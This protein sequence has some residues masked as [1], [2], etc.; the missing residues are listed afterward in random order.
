MNSTERHE[1]RYL[2]RLEKRMIKR[3]QSYSKYD[4][5]D[6]IFTYVNL[7]KSYRLSI[8]NVRWKP[9]IQK[10]IANAP[11]NV[12]K[13]F[14]ELKNGTF[15]SPGFFEF[16]V[17]ERGKKRHIR[18]V[19]VHERVV[20]RCICDNSLIPILSRTFIYDNGASMK[21]KGISFALNRIQCHLQRFIRK[22]GPNGY[23]LNFDFSKFF[24]NINHDVLRDII[25]KNFNDERVKALVFHFIDMFG[26][27]GLGL[28]SQV[29]Q[30]LSL[31]SAN[32]LDHY[33]KE[34]LRCPFYGRYMDDGYIIS[35]SKEFLSKCLDALKMIC[36]KL[37]IT[38]N[39]KKTR[40]TPLRR[41]FTF[42]KTRFFVTETGKIIK[43]ICHSSVTRM[44]RKMKKFKKKLECGKMTMA[45][46]YQSFQS[47][48]SHIRNAM[49]YR[50]EQS[51]TK[52]FK[53]LFRGHFYYVGGA[54]YVY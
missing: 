37:K 45:D 21:G 42:L 8:R 11:I 33:I 14:E 12:Y 27:I 52:L 10:Y 35:G 7:W 17:F 36:D 51:M 23:I 38:L 44:R 46:I 18:S 6:K 40:I 31:A 30:I 54:M 47:W 25:N 39:L 50:T 48:R 3:A 5:Y 15:K 19:G 9:S 26:D 4:S 20:Q 22:H 16:D 41:G 28:G 1:A 43:K 29:S 32:S 34:V 53:K 24:D 49:S 13:A 2:R